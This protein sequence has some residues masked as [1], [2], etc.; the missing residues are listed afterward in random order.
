MAAPIDSVEQ[1]DEVSAVAEAPPDE[2]SPAGADENTPISADSD[3]FGVGRFDPYKGLP[4]AKLTP[5]IPTVSGG[6]GLKA[7]RKVIAVNKDGATRCFQHELSKDK[8]QVPGDVVVRW[9]VSAKGEVGEVEVVKSTVNNEQIESCLVELVGK[10]AFPW[11]PTPL[12]TSVEHR[13][14]FEVRAP[15]P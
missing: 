7:V 2:A 8:D 15:R 12:P 11:P 4:R 14:T 9:V 6:F 3:G 1:P 10:Y 5:N 13:F